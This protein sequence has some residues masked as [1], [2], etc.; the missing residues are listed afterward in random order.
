MSIAHIPGFPRIGARR[1]LKWALESYWRGDST[2]EQLLAAGRE[3]RRRHWQMQREAGIDLI[4]VGDFSFY[5]HVLDTSALLGAVPERF[6]HDA[7]QVGLDVLFLMARGRAPGRADAV[8]C[9]M[10]K[11]FD[12]N[13]HYIVPEFRAGQDFRLCS[14]RLFEEAE[15]ARAL[16]HA[17]K[18]VLLGPLTYLW[19]GKATENFSRLG[20]LNALLPVYREILQRLAAAG[21]EWVQI[22]EPILSLDLPGRWLD[23]FEHA[24]H[25]LRGAPVRLLLTT[26]FGA[27]E[28]NAPVATALPV[29]GLHIDL[30]R[31]PGQLQPILDRLGDHKVLSLGLVDGRNI[32]RTD[33]QAALALA[34]QAAARL[35]ERLW[36][37]PSCSLLHCPLDLEV[38]TALDEELRAWLAFARQKLS[39]VVTLKRTIEE[40]E[41]A[42]AAALA[43]SRRAVQARRESRRVRDPV[44][45]GRMQEIDS[46]WAR[47]R[48]P[49]SLR[50]ARQQERLRLPLFPATTI[51]SFPQTDE[52]RQ[53][54]RQF[55][56]GRLSGAAYRECLREE[57][58][59]VVAAQERYGLDVLVHGEPERGD[60][61]EY[62][63]EALEGVA[64]TAHG[65]VQSYGS[66]CVRPPIIFGDVSRPAPITVQWSA[67]A[68]SLTSRPMKGMLTGPVTL[69][70]WS[71]A[72]E[73]LP[74]AEICLQLA[75]A[76]R[77]EVR[78]LEAAGL[79]IIQIDEPAFRE[80]LPLRQRD[81]HAYRGWATFAFR[82]AS[83]VVAD[84]TQIHTH[85]CYSEFNDIL[86]AID[87]LDADVITLETARSRMELLGAFARCRY[88][89]AI[90]PGIYDIHSP[91]VVSTDEMVQLAEKAFACIAPEDLWLNP[92]CGLK[93]RRWE[94]V[95]PAL[96][97][98]A[99]CARVLRARFAEEALAGAARGGS[100]D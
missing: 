52:I 32:W 97:N 13:Y 28:D 30:V 62:F 73:D 77:E 54:R 14:T 29:D 53:W 7:R 92:D 50:R 75:L 35:G 67:Y 1:E 99:R 20:L 78:D 17:I 25:T 61:V 5:D 31:A 15:E 6:G 11:W 3:L 91:R 59:R 84:A 24:Y 86:P 94:E 48:S 60:M 65:W 69:L 42:V 80:G 71:F 34:K 82:V 18:P 12:T 66:R 27:L 96:E 88:A 72:R 64:I 81:H 2:Q 90:G 85:M 100:R 41:Q 68:Q 55:R 39:E 79:R 57:I 49:Y 16:G 26:Y 4:C 58:G 37:A 45:R 44:V 40:G 9:D 10:T 70:Q 87:D 47:R 8:A 83:A 21:V 63:G 76:L 56:Q 93:T 98:L 22:D 43:E 74:R 36:I 95:E 33:L 46:A 89:R 19:L 51:G 38:E 23:G